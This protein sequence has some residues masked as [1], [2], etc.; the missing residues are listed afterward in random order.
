[1]AFS[2]LLAAPG[3]R[4]PGGAQDYSIAARHL[5]RPRDASIIPAILSPPFKEHTL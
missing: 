4:L 2:F 1:M 5:A 3:A